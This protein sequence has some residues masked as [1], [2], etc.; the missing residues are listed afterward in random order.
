MKIKLYKIVFTI[1]I[2]I[3]STYGQNNN[4]IPLE[5]YSSKKMHSGEKDGIYFKDL[6]NI[7]DAYVG[8]WRW[9]EGEKELIFYFYKDEEAPITFL[10]N[11]FEMDQ[12]FGY[13]VYKENDVVLIDTKP[14]LLTRI[15]NRQDT[16]R[17]GIGLRPTNTGYD[18][19]NYPVLNF[20]DYSK[21]ICLSIGNKPKTGRSGLWM[22]INPNTARIGLNTTGSHYTNCGIIDLQPGFPSN[23]GITITRI[24]NTAPPLD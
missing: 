24:S 2:G 14:I 17:G 15:D 21:E 11:T 10:N 23:Q 6:N 7:L 5:D 13:Y 3:T 18:N 8:V 19:Q 12:I 22:F 9:T 16:N 20:V 1:V 4:V